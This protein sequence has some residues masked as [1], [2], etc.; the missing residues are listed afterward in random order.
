M[1]WLSCAVVRANRQGCVASVQQG[2]APRVACSQSRLLLHVGGGTVKHERLKVEHD[3]KQLED[4]LRA[5]SGKDGGALRTKLARMR[6]ELNR[7]PAMQVVSADLQ[8]SL[9]ILTHDAYRA[10][11]VPPDASD[12]TLRQSFRKLSRLYVVCLG[13]G[14]RRFGADT[15]WHW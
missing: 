6:Q 2:A 15:R 8:T 14:L 7:I 10:L 4:L 11:Q 5:R 12:K 13:R 1:G 9:S 3:R